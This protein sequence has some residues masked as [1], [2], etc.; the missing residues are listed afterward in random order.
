MCLQSN[1]ITTRFYSSGFLRTYKGA[2]PAWEPYWLWEVQC[3]VVTVL[4]NYL[5]NNKR[6]NWV[7]LAIKYPVIHNFSLQRNLS[8]PDNIGP[9]PLSSIARVWNC[10]WNTEPIH[11]TIDIHDIQALPISIQVFCIGN[12]LIQPRSFSK[13]VYTTRPS[14]SWTSDVSDWSRH[15]QTTAVHD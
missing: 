3:Y 8:N 15:E 4:H 6:Q 12:K 11:I 10:I 9:G 2:L 14:P 1:K 5:H 7:S 13:A